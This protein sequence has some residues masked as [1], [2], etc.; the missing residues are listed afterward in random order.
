MSGPHSADPGLGGAVAWSA[1]STVRVEDRPAPHD[2]TAIIRVITVDRPAALNAIDVSTMRALSAAFEACAAAAAVRAVVVTGAGDKAFAAGAD[3]ASLSAMTA[4]EA[5]AFSQLG[6]RVGMQ[7]EALAVPVIAAVN[8]FALGGG[9]EL[10]LACDFIYAGEGARF[11]QPEVKL[12]AI[13]GFG[14]TFRLARRVGV[15]RARELLF[16]G[17]TIDAAESLRIGLC[18]RVFPAAQVLAEALRTAGAIA[19]R[20]PLAVAQAKR[21]LREGADGTPSG[22][23]ALETELFAELFATADLKLGMRAFLSKDNQPPRWQGR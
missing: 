4:D 11:G 12:G 1:A 5:A 10:A 20:A 23:A 21:A 17:E 18:N 6:H 14:G 9:C 8:G 2:A 15:A 7:I 16:T 22:A 13:P 3:V 19:A